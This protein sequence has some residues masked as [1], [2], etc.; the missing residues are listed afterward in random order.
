MNNAQIKISL[1]K[2]GFKAGLLASLFLIIYFLIMRALNLSG[3]P[4][5]WAFNFVILFGGINYCYRYYRVKTD[6]N[7][8]YL[9]GILLGTEVTAVSVVIYSLFIYIY[10]SSIDPDLLSMLGTN[11]LF[12][13]QDVTP[14]IASFATFIQGLSSGIVIAFIMMQYYKSGFK[15]AA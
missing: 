14:L 13:T 5:A 7:V 15:R 11:V 4:F 10:F 8:S 2:T 6:P 3:N 12:M 1:G 9:P